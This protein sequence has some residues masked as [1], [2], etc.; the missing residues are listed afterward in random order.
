MIKLTKLLKESEENS[1][2]ALEKEFEKGFE[3]FVN[4][5]EQLDADDFDENEL[6]E[7]LIAVS[8][9][10]SGPK[11]INYTARMINWLTKKL[12]SSKIESTKLGNFLIKWAG[13]WEHVYVGAIKQALKRSGAAK[14]YGVKDD[15]ELDKLASVT[16]FSILGV[17]AVTSGVGSAEAF[18]DALY[19][20]AKAGYG[21]L[22]AS[23]AGI[24]SRE[25]YKGII[26]LQK[27]K[28]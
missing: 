1:L 11:I 19:G 9:L 27:S 12:T 25:I 24:K 23:L 28:K 17:A 2:S 8:I 20:A 7:S 5:V 3:E 4:N 16:Y 10:M 15:A 18:V 26:E 21:G 6:N 22:K 13:K 14:K